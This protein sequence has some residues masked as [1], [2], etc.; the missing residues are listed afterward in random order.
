MIRLFKTIRH[1]WQLRGYYSYLS[2]SVV[3][4][5]WAHQKFPNEKVKVY[6]DLINIPHYKQENLF[7]VCFEQDHLDFVTN[8]EKYINI[9]SL[10]S[11]INFNHYDLKIFP[12][13]LRQSAELI[14]K[15]YFNL[16]PNLI[17]E[18]NRRL[19]SIDLEN[20]ISVH[21]RD[22]DMRVG[23]HITAPVLE[24]YYSIIDGGNWKNIFLM[25]DNKQDLD[26]FLERYGDK[27]ITYEDDTTSDDIDNPFFLKEGTT[28]ESM[29]KHIENLTLNTIILS[30][31]KKL[32]C[33][34]S[35]LST[36]A[37]LSNPNL[38]YVKL[39]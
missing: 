26:L 17:L 39:N 31:T 22:T 4:I 20:T 28:K 37:I 15:E 5:I 34:K 2:E 3:E 11:E 27:I 1:E 21:R 36:F 38:E 9:E 29:K 32:L 19:E 35:N 14:I 25:S 10:N 23:H 33:S 24:Q 30:K 18:L 6:F 13:D 12:Q 16:K 7:D 8:R